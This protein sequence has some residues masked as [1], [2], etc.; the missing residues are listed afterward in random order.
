[1]KNFPFE[2]NGQT[3]W[4]SRSVACG[5]ITF[6]YD[7]NFK[8]YVLANKRGKGCLFN[9]GKWNIAGG[10]IDFDEDAKTCAA[11]ETFEECGIIIDPN[12]MH[13]INVYTKPESKT[14][15]IIIRFCYLIKDKFV[16]ELTTSNKNSEP[17]EVEEIKWIP[18]DELHK[19]KWTRDQQYYIRIAADKMHVNKSKI[20]RFILKLLSK[21]YH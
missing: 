12:R 18:L 3:L 20:V 11:R 5:C 13:F 2:H 17:D 4:Y 1:M 19:Y 6:A 16:D 9:I 8:P 7:R 10:F 14:Q 15:T 21:I